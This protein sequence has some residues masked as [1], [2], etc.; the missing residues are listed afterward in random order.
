MQILLAM[1]AAYLG[2]SHGQQK[3][4][5]MLTPEILAARK[6]AL[7]KARALINELE[8]LLKD[9][10]VASEYFV[11]PADA[12]KGDSVFFFVRYASTGLLDETK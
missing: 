9:A 8:K 7:P 10:R 1:R 11:L 3:E 2:A 4:K 12:K 5:Q 6:E